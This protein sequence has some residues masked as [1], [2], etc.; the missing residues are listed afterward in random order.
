[1]LV[2]PDK[3]IGN[4]VLVRLRLE[5]RPGFPNL[6]W[7][8]LDVELKLSS[9]ATEVECFPCNRWISTADGDVELRSSR[10]KACTVFN[11]CTLV[12]F[13]CTTY[14]EE[15]KVKSLDLRRMKIPKV[16]NCSEIILLDI[17]AVMLK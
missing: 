7:H 5:A 12:R 6:D 10:G 13:F 9:D 11:W 14:Q 3:E 4:V 8:C 16:M 2:K 15:S 1:M 17:F